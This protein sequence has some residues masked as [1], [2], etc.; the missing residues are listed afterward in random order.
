MNNPP[1]RIAR[2]PKDI[3]G[4][5][6][7]FFVLWKDDR[8]DFQV[9]DPLKV[10]DCVTNRLCW[11]CGQRLGRFLTFVIGPMSSVNRLSAEPPSHLDCAK[12]AAQVCPFLTHPNLQ[13]RASEIHGA[14]EVVNLPGPLSPNPGITLVW[15][16]TDCQP[17]RHEGHWWF[18][19]GAPTTSIW[20]SQGRLATR[21]E[22]AAAFERLLPRLHDIAVAEGQLAGFE[23]DAEK[24][25]ALWPTN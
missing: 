22:V 17:V 11:I 2:L 25:R 10:N 18:V 23:A 4:R 9:V 20:Y 19:L 3:K 16:T 15:V 21:A 12:Y 14:E 1:E 8:P 24:A 13:R 5:P 6:V 7:P